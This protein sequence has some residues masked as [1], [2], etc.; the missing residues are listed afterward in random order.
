MS[1]LSATAKEFKFNPGASSFTPNFGGVPAA[2]A[3]PSPGPQSVSLRNL[4]T[5]AQTFV[6]SASAATFTP[7]TSGNNNI[8]SAP[9][10][11]QNNK[12]TNPGPPHSYGGSG[13]G[14]GAVGVNTN[15]SPSNTPGGSQR[16]STVGGNPNPPNQNQNQPPPPPAHTNATATKPLQAKNNPAQGTMI[17]PNADVRNQNLAAPQ[18]R[19]KSSQTSKARRGAMV[20]NKPSTRRQTHTMPSAKV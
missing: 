13:S 2:T 20:Q 7:T 14:R 17:D 18:V 3:Q 1:K 15:P 10:P 9:D 16:G 12:I 4:S 8:Y 5:A 6:P 19:R 11:S